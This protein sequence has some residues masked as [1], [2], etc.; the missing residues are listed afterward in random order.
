MKRDSRSVVARVL[1]G[2]VQAAE[3]RHVKLMESTEGLPARPFLGG[4]SL[5][6][7]RALTEIAIFSAMVSCLP[8]GP[9]S[10]VLDL[11][12][13]PCW[14]SE[15]LQWLRYRTLS[16]DLVEDMLAIGCRRLAPGS[17]ACAADMAAL[18]LR[19]GTMDAALCYGALH[20]RRPRHDSLRGPDRGHALSGSCASRGHHPSRPTVSSPRA[21]P[22][23]PPRRP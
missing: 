21:G 2:D 13:G 23:G 18:P 17:W 10:L 19:A 12:A 4:T 3:R 11:G 1:A 20:L 5:D 8:R 6:A 22:P 15:W 16:L 7:D 9:G 14:V